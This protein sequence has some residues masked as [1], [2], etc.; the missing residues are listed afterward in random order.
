MTEKESEKY[1]ISIAEEDFKKFK[2][3]LERDKFIEERIAKIE[4]EKF[5]LLLESKDIH[6]QGNEI[7]RKTIQESNLT[8]QMKK[9]D[10]QI[11]MENGFMIPEL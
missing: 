2:Q 6:H 1:K 11:D 3:T 9:C 4:K 5:D 10:F 8:D 7:L